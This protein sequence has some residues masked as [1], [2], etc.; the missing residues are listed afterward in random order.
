MVHEEK[1]EE[2]GI[3]DRIV[4]EASVPVV[5]IVTKSDILSE[6]DRKKFPK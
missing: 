4:N 6:K 5:T 3:I 1:G 2:E